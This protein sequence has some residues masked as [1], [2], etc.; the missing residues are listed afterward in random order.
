LRVRC[1]ISIPVGARVAVECCNAKISGE[2]RY[3][4]EQALDEFTIGI[5]EIGT[6]GIDLTLFL[7]PTARCL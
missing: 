1:P 2:V 7:L 6:G 3:M 5:K 4:R